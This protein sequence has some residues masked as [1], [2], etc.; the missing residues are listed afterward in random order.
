LN[1]Y[2]SWNGSSFTDAKAITS[3]TQTSDDLDTAGASNNTWGRSWSDTEF[4][5][6]NFRVK[7]NSATQSYQ[8][9]LDHL[10]IKVYYTPAG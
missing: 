6:A 2:L 5:D 1:V 4:S 3:I 10:Q 8:Y 9:H 7:I